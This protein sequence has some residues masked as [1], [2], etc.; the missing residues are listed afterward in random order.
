MRRFVLAAVMFFIASPM[1]AA[2]PENL[3]KPVK[4]V[5][6][7]KTVKKKARS[8][9]LKL[10][11]EEQKTLYAVGLVMARQLASFELTPEELRIVRLGLTD[12]IRGRKSRVDFTKYSKKSQEL[13]IARRD[14]AGKK[15][16]AK[17]ADFIEA[18][19]QV[20]GA[21]KTK[22]GVIFLSLREGTGVQPVETDTVK[23]DFRNTLIDGKE[24]D[25]TYKNG[26]PE[27]AKA[28]EFLKCMTEGVLLMKPGGKS[29]IV[30]PPDTALGKES[31]GLIPPN[32]T[33]VYEVELL[34]IIK[35]SNVNKG[36]K[37][38]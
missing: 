16:E 1:F 7:A 20:E 23:L 10:K 8:K 31:F 17:A 30:C 13:G 25:S 12:G 32:A 18:A 34:E 11:T 22:S 27:S 36:T 26:A 15:L 29:R 21:V 6:P 2:G 5:E 14:A 24:M 3:P 38:E 19:A 4:K 37:P 35:E 33:L 28:N 9:E